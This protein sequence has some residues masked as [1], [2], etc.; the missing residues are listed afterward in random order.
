MAAAILTIQ[1]G[2][3]CMRPLQAWLNVFH[4]WLTVSHACSAALHWWR[5][6]SH[7]R[8]GVRMGVVLN[9]QVVM[10][11]ASNLGWGAV[12]EGRGVRVSWPDCWTS[13][14]LN[15]LE[16]QAVSLAL[17]HFL[18]VLSGTH[19]L[20]R[21]DNTTVVAYI[22]HHGDLRSPGLHRTAFRLLTWVQRNLL[23]LRA[24]HI[25]GAVNWAAGLLSRKGPHPSEWQLHHQTVERIWERFGKA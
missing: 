23:S 12:W 9:R 18:P 8:E 15:M 5:T 10:T 3:L 7:L 13:L 14:H 19:V 6:T 17:H 4:R 22:H 20:I 24:T 21:T 11:D 1:L 2:L 16:L 25:P